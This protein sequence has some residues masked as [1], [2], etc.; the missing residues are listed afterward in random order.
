MLARTATTIKFF[1]LNGGPAGA[2][3]CTGSS[4]TYDTLHLNP[5]FPH[6]RGG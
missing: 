4:E 3:C 6:N 2:D 5:T 1:I